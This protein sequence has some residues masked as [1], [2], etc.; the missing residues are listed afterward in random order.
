M[1]VRLHRIEVFQ[2][3][4]S[5]DEWSTLHS[6]RWV[7]M[8]ATDMERFHSLPSILYL[9]LD[10]TTQDYG[11]RFGCQSFWKIN[12]K[13]F[14]LVIFT[15]EFPQQT[16]EPCRCNVATDGWNCQDQYHKTRLT[17]YAWM[18]T[19]TSVPCQG[20]HQGIQDIEETTEEVTLYIRQKGC[21]STAHT[22]PIQHRLCGYSHKM[23]PIRGI[24]GEAL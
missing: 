11:I 14:S 2:A 7:H 1:T 22:V 16:G 23:P 9:S 24:I 15:G 17:S 4:E 18:I 10:E 6:V 13:E 3:K 8:S 5:L 19:I 20:H 12:L 21:E